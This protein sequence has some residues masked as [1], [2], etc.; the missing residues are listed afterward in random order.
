MSC[1]RWITSVSLEVYGLLSDVIFG[2]TACN[3][4]DGP[5]HLLPWVAITRIRVWITIIVVTFLIFIIY[6][7]LQSC[8]LVFCAIWEQQTPEFH[9]TAVVF[10]T[11]E[12][13]NSSSMGNHRN[14]CLQ[15][16]ILQVV[17]NNYLEM[18]GPKIWGK[19]SLLLRLLRGLNRKFSM[20]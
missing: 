4:A 14:G 18:Y 10:F 15:L 17:S 5:A 9:L 3:V 19:Y 2:K 6:M 12:T 8:S 11:F 16:T 7:D 13:S 20:S 1:F